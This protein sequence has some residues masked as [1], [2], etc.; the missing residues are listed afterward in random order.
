MMFI[1]FSKLLELL[2]IFLTIILFM[3]FFLDILFMS[4]SPSIISNREYFIFLYSL[5]FKTHFIM[6][7]ISFLIS[8]Q[9]FV[10]YYI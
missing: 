9:L 2:S 8:E 5:S 7:L 3:T 10:T 4:K 6:L 1:I